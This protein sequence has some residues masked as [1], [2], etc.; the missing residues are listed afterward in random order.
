MP[1]LPRLTGEVRDTRR[2]VGGQLEQGRV[3]GPV[4]L[5]DGLVITSATWGSISPSIISKFM[6]D[7]TTLPPLMP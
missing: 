1:R 4:E 3:D 7:I 6:R 2:L 5:G